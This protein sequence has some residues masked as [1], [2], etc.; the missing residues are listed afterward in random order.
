MTATMTPTPV[1]DLPTVSGPQ[2]S[3]SIRL[4]AES[5]LR[6]SGYLALRDV[7]CDVQ[8][9]TARLR[10]HLPTYYLKQMAQATVTQVEG[11]RRVVNL[12][13]VIVPAG[14]PSV[15]PDRA[16]QSYEPTQIGRRFQIV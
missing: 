6:R 3:S 10:G 14:R 7:S 11:V 15:G 2:D 13:E 5:R 1:F 4:E 16:A 12:I 9:G 8:G